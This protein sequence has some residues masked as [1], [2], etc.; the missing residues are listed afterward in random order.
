MTWGDS[1]RMRF[2]NHIKK[3][4]LS[5]L[6]PQNDGIVIFFQN[7]FYMDIRYTCIGYKVSSKMYRGS[8]ISDSSTIYT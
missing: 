4:S 3:N 1:K 5:L 7:T 2:F 8:V 6:G